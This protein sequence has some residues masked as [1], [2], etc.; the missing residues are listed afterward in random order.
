VDEDLLDYMHAALAEAE[1]A[2]AR[3]D[4]AVGAVLVV[5]GTVVGRGGNRATT[6]GDP[7]AH[8]ETV[9]LRHFALRNPGRTLERGML[10]TTFEPCPM[11][12][13]ACLVMKVG[14]VVVGGQ[15]DPGDRAW[16]GYRPGHLADT[17]AAGG[18]SLRVR[19]G[20]LGEECRRLRNGTPA[21]PDSKYR[22][23]ERRPSR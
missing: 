1:D 20:P 17:V 13:G 14:T 2:G 8:A 18:W 4:L 21:L 7:L 12:L 15:R 10:V 5:D 22:R 11:C 16:G 6:A 9:A 23:P 19:P 3:G